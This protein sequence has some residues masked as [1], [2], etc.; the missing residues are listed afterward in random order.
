MPSHQERVRR[1][2]PEG[3]PV[4]GLR[5]CRCGDE[6]FNAS[7]RCELCD[8]MF[9]REPAA[10]SE[11]PR[12]PLT[13]TEPPVVHVCDALPAA[14]LVGCCMCGA[15]SLGMKTYSDSLNAYVW[16]CSG[17]GVVTHLVSMHEYL[18]RRLGAR[19]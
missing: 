11:V 2:Y 3:V 5:V 15:A 1:N 4:F 13:A 8:S 16:N 6:T 17:C 12:P 14:D 18:N 19:G 10:M 9:P 7:G